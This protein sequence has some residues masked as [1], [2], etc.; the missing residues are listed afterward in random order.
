MWFRLTDDATAKLA[1]EGLG[2]TSVSREEVTHSLSFGGGSSTSGGS[3]GAVQY[4]D[5][6]LIRPEW[7]TGLPRGEAFVRTRGENWKLRVP[8]LEP[9]SRTELEEVAGHF[10]LSMV[11]AE[12]KGEAEAEEGGTKTD[13]AMAS[14]QQSGEADG[15]GGDSSGSDGES[16]GKASV[17]KLGSSVG[18]LGASIDVEDDVTEEEGQNAMAG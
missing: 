15:D 12:L 5:R 3:R 8:L 7:M 4:V 13:N 16:G 14:G 6:P 17:Q 1:V 9:V 2:T 11:I 10:G 18:E